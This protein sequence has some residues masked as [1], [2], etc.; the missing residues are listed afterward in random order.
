MNPWGT[1]ND[2]LRLEVDERVRNY[3]RVR[4]LQRTTRR[5]RP[6]TIARPAPQ[7]TTSTPV[8]RDDVAACA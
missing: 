4:Q 5:R 1:M 6:W 7:I 3:G 8:G 2:W